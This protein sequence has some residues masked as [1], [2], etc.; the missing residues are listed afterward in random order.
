MLRP[1]RSLM[2]LLCLVCIL[3]TWAGGALPL[4]KLEAGDLDEPVS[5]ERSLLLEDPGAQLTASEVLQRIAS[6][7]RE[8]E[9]TPRIGYSRSA[10]WL[11]TQVQA[12]AAE[13]LQLIIGQTFLDD[14]EIWLYDGERPLGPLYSGSSR[15]FSERGEPYPHFLL[16]LPR[17][18]AG[19][20]TLL[21]RVQSHSA[22]NLPL[23]LVGAEQGQ[24]LIAHS[25]LR[26]GLLIGA[27]L[28][29]ALFYLIRYSTL[30]EWPLACFGLTSLSTALYNASIY[31]LAGL[32]W[33]QWPMLPKL[34][35]NLPTA[36]MM[37]F[38]S[39]FIA[40]AL[41]LRLKRLRWLR[42]A[43]FAA[44]LLV[45]VGGLL[46]DHPRAYEVL[47]L[48]ILATGLYQLL[49]LIIGVRQRRP[50]A[51]GYLLCWSAALM[52]ML[53]VPLGRAGLVPLP[54]GF[55][56]MYAYLPA[57]SM[58]LFGAL[59]DK[60]LERVRRVLLSSQAQ[61]IDNLEQYQALF[62]H[63]GEGI[64]RC[65]RDGRLLEANPSLARLL[66]REALPANLDALALPSLVGET[67]WHELLSQL[68][69]RSGTASCE[70]QLYDLEQR[71][72]WVY[73]SLHLRPHQDCIEGI[74]VDLSERRAL[75]ERLQQLAAHDALTGLLNRRELERLLAETLGGT[76]KRRFSHLLLLGLDRFK[77]VND[78]CGHSAGDQ[79]LR[80]LASQLLHQLPRHAELARVGGDEFA[81]LLREVDD[82]AALEQAEQ[83][84]RGVEQFVFTWQGRPFR[85]H[86]S[87][88]MLALGS[89]V[90]DWETALNWATS[91]SQLAKHQGRNRVQQFNPA[92]GALLE[93]QRQL[94][95]ITR[96][97]EATERGHFE[98]FFQPV[99][100]LQQASSGLHYEV[101]LRY[102]D[103]HNG[104][105]ISPAQF[106]D[107]AA[108]YDFLGAIDRW[109]IQH[110]CAWLAANPR[111]LAQLA[112]VNVNLSASSL[113]D[114]GFHHLL[115]DELQRHGLPPSK[116]CIE[117]T[118]M[119]ALGELGVSAQWIEQLRG[120][121]LKV[122]LD[123][124]GS[125]FASYAYLRHLPLD[126][127]KIDGSFI[128]GI[129]RDPINQAMVGSMRQIAGQLGLLT[130]AE[131]VETQASLDCLRRLGIDYAQGYFVGR[132]QPLHLL[133]DDVRHHDT[134]DA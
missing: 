130:V 59:L 94:Q 52:L 51:P 31:N 36:G 20:H 103:P 109:V 99:Q 28:A 53:L 43:L 26:S 5:I 127:L 117:V 85:L 41:G 54:A 100:A 18:D 97:R 80:Q 48:L 1:L 95:W 23:Q 111:H 22:I 2:T 75:E 6:Q 122:A 71:P 72:R 47:N 74:V 49:L 78:L 25:W 134:Q 65:R 34:L 8:V 24:Q 4:L 42:D 9:G 123:D 27:L 61:A 132:P 108:R 12:P 13:R 120:K 19:V 68:D 81:V 129:E 46:V 45:S 15:A 86:A 125:G 76:A 115:Q 39:L 67:Q 30:R 131:F 82:E 93:H 3:P 7:G 50:Y 107:A 58:L 33:P 38:S 77:Q 110:L 10:W 73:L 113:L 88:G 69:A 114:S 14:L 63:S 128:S 91:A 126:I 56:A 11:A 124:F 66:G 64:F 89:G 29:L 44:S 83:L 70:C 112:Q 57:L 37:I 102:R 106:L 104:D 133:A 32:L 40:S 90:S 62:R 98:L 105:W 96:L 35:V 116:L 92:D 119:V 87:I 60:Q 101:L 55:Y 17:L 84:R 16:N 79:L 121:G 21:L 118:E